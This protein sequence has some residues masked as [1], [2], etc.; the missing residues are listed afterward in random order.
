MCAAVPLRRL[1]ELAL[2]LCLNASERPNTR[3]LISTN[4]CKRFVARAFAAHPLRRPRPKRLD[5]EISFSHPPSCVV[6]S[7]PV[8]VQTPK[9][10]NVWFRSSLETFVREAN[11]R[12][13]RG[14]GDLKSCC[15]SP[16]DP[17]S[18]EKTRESQPCRCL[19]AYPLKAPMPGRRACG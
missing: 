3:F 7:I 17:S 9:E 19:Y 14:M 10:L 18:I 15:H 13:I 12:R 5:V 1:S 11:L 6:D 4:S 16:S 2:W 8:H